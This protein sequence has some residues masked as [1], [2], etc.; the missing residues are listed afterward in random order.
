MKTKNI[1]SVCAIAVAVVTLFSSCSNDATTA[2]NENGGHKANDNQSAYVALADA[3]VCDNSR[4]GKEIYVASES[5]YYVCDGIS[6][7]VK[8]GPESFP[9]Y[10]SATADY[11]SSS[12]QPVVRSCVPGT[13]TDDGHCLFQDDRDFTEYK[14]VKIGSQIW[15]A[16]F[17]NFGMNV[18]SDAD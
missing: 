6:W 10:S 4:Y 16:E 11:S 13:E 3:G 8:A 17:L 5:R 14:W 1:A 15:M 18:Y 9:G 12:S 7:M 2:G